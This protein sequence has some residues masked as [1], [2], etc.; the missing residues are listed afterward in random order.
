M[1]YK[2]QVM[3]YRDEFIQVNEDL[4]GTSYLRKY[5]SYEEWLKFVQD[6]EDEETKH[7]HVTANVYLAIREEDNKLL[8]MINIRHALNEYLFN[9]GGHIGYSIRQDERRKGYAK[10]M[11]SMALEIAKQLAIHKVL[12]TCDATNPASAKTILYCGG[13]LENEIL[14]GDELVQRYWIDNQ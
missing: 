4:T 9:Y 10:E 6:N 7:A 13:V 2:D 8:G 12:V 11:L 5:E 3:A 1:A 14:E